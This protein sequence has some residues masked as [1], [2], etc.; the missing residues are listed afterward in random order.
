MK[1]LS[2]GR[3]RDHPPAGLHPPAH[4]EQEVTW[5]SPSPSVRMVLVPNPLPARG[6]ADKSDAQTLLLCLPQT[7]AQQ[8]DFL[9]VLYQVNPTGICSHGC[10]KEGKSIPKQWEA[11]RNPGGVGNT[12]EG[13]DQGVS[14][15]PRTGAGR[16]CKRLFPLL[17][18]TEGQS[19]KCS[20]LY[21]FVCKYSCYSLA[22]YSAHFTYLCTA[23]WG[24]N[25][26]GEGK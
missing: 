5:L 3:G 9:W 25:S 6:A 12:Q 15:S 16:R 20:N 18:C 14:L 2:P 19:L 1:Q 8:G 13:G 7:K 17:S 21:I 4:E 11:W 10:L 24:S 26:G 23:L 22:M